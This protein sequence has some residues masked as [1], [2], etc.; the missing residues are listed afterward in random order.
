M[1]GRAAQLMSARRLRH[2]QFVLDKVAAAMRT[3]VASWSSG[4]KSRRAAWVGIKR[5]LAANPIGEGLTVQQWWDRL[6]PDLFPPL[7][8]AARGLRWPAAVRA[9]VTGRLVQ[10][11]L[12]VVAAAA[13]E[14]WICSL[15]DDDPLV[16]A[17][18][19]L[20]EALGRLGWPTEQGIRRGTRAGLRVMLVNDYDRLSQFVDADVKA[21]PAGGPNGT[22]M[23]DVA[24][25][26]AGIFTRSPQRGT[27]RR[28]AEPPRTVE[29]L[30]AL[31]IPP[32]F[33][34]VTVAYVTAYQQ[35]VSRNYSTTRTRSA[36]WRTS[37]NT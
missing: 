25:C 23:L 1:T 8:G 10:P 3:E 12:R 16:I 5:F 11:N 21:I 26:A 37:G 29:Q 17:H 6:E 34:K 7:A 28:K 15:P 35:R 20:R 4:Q 14:P 2:Q 19:Q 31:R 18:R 32:P 13:V 33:D 36:H 30:V 27:S 24:L 9:L 22:D